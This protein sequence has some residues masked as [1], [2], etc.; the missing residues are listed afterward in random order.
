MGGG[1]A[2]PAWHRFRPR[3]SRAGWPA[4]AAALFA[5]GP[6]GAHGFGERYELPLPLSLY[7]FGAAAAIVVS[8]VIA[9][10][11]VR[12]PREPRAGPRIDL[13]AWP[14][15]RLIAHDA[16]ALALKLVALALFLVAIVAGFIGSEDPYRNIAPTLIWIIWWVGFAYV[17]A[18]AG[19]LW[20]L[21]NP[22]R[23]MFDAA[24]W[25][26]Q[27]AVGRNLSLDRP[28]PARLGGWPA[29]LLLLGFSWIELVYP[30]P[31]L[32]L[33]L[34]WFAIGYSILTLG[35][36]VL[37]GRDIWLRHGEVFTVMFATFA[38]FAPTEAHAGPPRQLLLRPFGA[39]LLDSAGVSNAM[40]AFVLLLL[41][42]V[43]F[44]G[45][46]TSPEWTNLESAL[47]ARLS[48][49]G[50]L[51]PTAVKTAGLI[52]FWLM[53]SAAYLGT[54]A[55][56]SFVARQRT[57]LEVARGFAF[58]LVPIAIGYHVAHYLTFLLVQGQ[59][60]IPLVSDPFG[61]GWNLFGTA[62]YR[63]DIALVGARFAWYAALAAVL[64]GHIAAVYLAHRK[65]MQLFE[66]GGLALR[67]QVPLTALMVVYTF[68]SLS[69]LAEPVVERREPAQPSSG[70]AEV[71]VPA[72]AVLP[73]PGSGRLSAVGAGKVARA[74]L[75]YR[76]LGSAFHDGSKTTIADLVY[77]TMFA[78]RWGVRREGN[79]HYDP[80]I[81]AATA[82]MRR[83]LVA[84]RVVGTDAGAKSFRVADVNFVRELFI[85]EVYAAVA[86]EDPE[87]DAIVLPPWS[88]LP[89][90]VLA[91]MEEAVSR[92]FAAFSQAEAQR[93]GVE[94]L[95]LVR[96]EQT[97]ARLAALIE[98]FARD[99]YRPESLRSLVSADDA[100]KRWAALAAFHKISGHVLVTNGP[101][102]LKRWSG[103]SATLEAFRDLSYPLGVGSFDAYAIPRRGF[104]TA[105]EW[106]GRRATLT[107]DI[108]IVEKFQRS[109]R[110][111]RTPLQSLGPEVARRAA[112]E[113][114][115]TIVDDQ[116]RVVLAG[117]ARL[118]E[119]STFRVDLGG[120][121]P[122]GRYTMF[123]VIALAGNVMNAEIRRI[124]VTIASAP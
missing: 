44:D 59:Y 104:V 111:T 55:I 63:V 113:C 35:G 22:W 115:Y 13:L 14:L 83:H 12:R 72:D 34:A 65:A 61:Y 38:R 66:S 75:T 53:L 122:A 9:G 71:A 80:F 5:A 57:P 95:D 16:V 39:G 119:D 99:G 30:N 19:D 76:V 27:K 4:L 17:S 105:V 69:I 21:I 23:T 117:L 118:A 28:Y 85:I 41:A 54:C 106:N 89:W 31:A 100:R 107:G 110:L 82:P 37:F 92:G 2:P 124:P 86:P 97:K 26:R 109:Y 87:Q 64:T 94:W 77:S 98:T 3:Q 24:E 8:F 42:T 15:G 51:A 102:R 32:P 67:S 73:E 62:G 90:H 93:R 103:E 74:K 84:L 36:M 101:Y 20:R 114:R 81:D 123:A 58:T 33:H 70:A 112:P 56:M 108:E 10:L 1:G 48:L 29:L 116:E 68:V 79:A 50:E 18:F 120:R 45:A 46:S 40:T 43:L 78:Y 121:L 49:F 6:A 88:V 52:A 7:L 96:P 60:I 47:A 91:L 25:L 11:F